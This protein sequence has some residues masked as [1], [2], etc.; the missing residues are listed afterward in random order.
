MTCRFVLT[1][2]RMEPK[3]GTIVVRHSR[4]HAIVKVAGG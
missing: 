3:D 4:G 1:A 2:D